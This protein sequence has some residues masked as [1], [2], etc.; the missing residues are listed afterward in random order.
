MDVQ[1]TARLHVIALL[2]P[3]VHDERIFAFASPYNWT[4]VLAILQKLRPQKK[5]PKAPDNEGRDLSDVVPSK[6]AEALLKE[7]FGRPGWTSLEDSLAE[8]IAD[9]V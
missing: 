5:L 4:D 9:I 7:Y 2:A 6:R 1:D 3:A 8:G